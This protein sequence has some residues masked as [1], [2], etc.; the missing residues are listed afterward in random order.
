[1]PSMD[2]LNLPIVKAGIPF[3]RSL[4]MNDYLKFITLNLRDTIDREAVREQKKLA[5][6][7]EQF[8]IKKLDSGRL[9]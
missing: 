7:N 5:V 8:S 4:S 2:K 3:S 6:V 9:I 1:M